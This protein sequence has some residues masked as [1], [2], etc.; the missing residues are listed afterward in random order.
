MKK[1]LFSIGDGIYPYRVGGMEIFNYYLIKNL[2]NSF[3]IYY[4]ASKKFDFDN[5]RILKTSSKIKPIKITYPLQLFLILLF[6]PS[7]KCVVFSYSASH[8]IIW[9]LYTLICQLLKTHYVVVIHH[10]K[11][12]PIEKQRTYFNFF[13]HA[14]KVIAVSPDIKKNFDQQF[15]LDCD[16]IYPLVPFEKSTSSKQE[17]RQQYGIPQ[18]AKVICMVGTIKQM[19]NPDTVIN[20][21]SLMNESELSAYNPYV[22]FAGSGPM[23]E[24]LKQMAQELGIAQ[25]IKFLGFVSKEK[26]NEIMK[27]SDAYLISSDFEGTSVSLLEA[28]FNKMAIIAS[29]APGIID[30][31]LDGSEC[32]MFE[33]KNQQELKNCII[34]TFSNSDAAK[35]RAQKAFEHYDNQFSYP[36][37][38][39]R[40]STILSNL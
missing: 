38:I 32:L 27:L 20:A 33:T 31:I 40:Y 35:L 5:V 39:N 18:D 11:K 25:R 19:K 17:L 15:Q 28:M 22:V 21:I 29:R 23:L 13:H 34:E 1:I 7:I 2:R 37:I 14:K 30:T 10:G 8:W 12:P 6:H 9:K 4:A 16:V 3:R 24:T 36:D 26:I